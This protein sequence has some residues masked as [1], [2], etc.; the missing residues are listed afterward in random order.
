MIRAIWDI[1]RAQLRARRYKT[2]RNTIE[3]LRFSGSKPPRVKAHTLEL[4]YK[5]RM[6]KA[7]FLG[8]ALSLVLIWTLRSYI[9]IIQS[10]LT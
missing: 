10:I 7:M 1:L 5:P 4:F 9:E 6:L 3:V 8:A 2:Q